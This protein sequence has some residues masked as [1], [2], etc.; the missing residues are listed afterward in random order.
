MDAKTHKLTIQSRTWLACNARVFATAGTALVAPIVLWF[1]GW[2]LVGDDL[3]LIRWGAFVAPWL[4]LLALL[5]SI[6]FAFGKR[7]LRAGLA[8]VLALLIL[9]PT[10]PR[11]SPARW[12]AASEARDLR[13][14]TFNTSELNTDF[15]AIAKVIVRERPDIVFLQQ[16]RD[17]SALKAE[18]RRQP[19]H[20]DYQSFP[21]QTADTVILSR[22]PL[23]EGRIFADQRATALTTIRNCQIRLWDLHA[24]H[25]QYSVAE[26]A[27]FFE[28]TAVATKDEKL[29]VIVGGDLNSTEFN[30]DQTPLRAE[31]R[32]AFADV[33][34]GLGF[35][36]PSHVRRFG[37]FGRL[38]RID[39]I[40]YRGLTPTSAR[41]AND[42]A[43]SDH[44]AVEATFR[45]I[46][47]CE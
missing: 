15:T 43:N 26:Q 20:L 1:V 9:V 42:N 12:F 16:I 14:M 13:A 29:P 5:S 17:L 45:R 34:S 33:G 4:A 28:E 23:I 46:G 32:D 39:H 41:T 21:P 3:L 24:P 11:F 37:T 38:F 47:G 30:S 44:F 2:L 35:T 8:V 25:G 18:I 6:L 27:L 19:G 7:G 22:F 10:L 40:F 36:F 31:F